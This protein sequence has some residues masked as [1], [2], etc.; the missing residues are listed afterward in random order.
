[1]K[2]LWI[3]FI[4]SLLAGQLGGFT[5]V[6]GITVYLHD[7]ML[8]CLLLGSII[9]IYRKNTFHTPRLLYPAL[10]FVGA[11]F[12]SLVAQVGQF[13][14]LEL[15]QSSLYLLRFAT[16]AGLYVVLSQSIIS[17]VLILGGLM[18]LGI[19]IAGIGLVQ[20][21]VFPSLA[22]FIYLGWDPHY[23]RVFATLLDPN[24]TG[25]VLVMS[26]FLCLGILRFG[27]PAWR[28]IAAT[29]VM[30]SF[31]AL[32][33]TFSRSSYLA[34]VVGLAVW[35][36]LEKK[37]I[38]GGLITFLFIALV[39]FMPRPG[40]DTL[41]LD[42][43]DSTLARFGNWKESVNLFIKKPL[44]GYGFNTLRFVQKPAGEGPM[45]S[46]VFSHALAGVDNSFLLV[47][48]TTGLVGFVPFLWLLAAMIQKQR[49]PTISAAKTY[50]F[51][52]QVSILSVVSL[53]VHS[54]FVNSW[55]YPW[56]LLWVFILL[57]ITEATSGYTSRAAQR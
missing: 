29:G 2:Y 22:D 43:L 37:W 25:I 17:P 57:G 4:V 47:L 13:S 8:M 12:I 26:V 31:I 41:R 1:M 53:S 50:M 34:F 18:S 55:F 28:K 20:F 16:Y 30:L 44:W 40:G 9:L 32:I 49:E 45:Y 10:A 33:L 51:L 38:L 11:G 36:I 42:R 27:V 56:S 15:A 35:V 23:Y 46:P 5:I 14:L 48:V 7:V 19:G 6:P 39:V 3:A 21:V 24:F 54:L 52:P